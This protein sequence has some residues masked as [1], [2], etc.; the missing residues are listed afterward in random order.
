MDWAPHSSVG[1]VFVEIT[2]ADRGHGGDGCESGTCLW[3]VCSFDFGA[4]YGALG[5]GYIECHHLKPL[6]ERAEEEQLEGAVTPLE[7]VAVVRA[8]SHSMLRRRRPT[9]TVEEL[10]AVLVELSVTAADTTVSTPTSV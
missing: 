8:N 6:A 7:D 4:R 3:Q 2:K 9:L 10:R 5:E 1:R